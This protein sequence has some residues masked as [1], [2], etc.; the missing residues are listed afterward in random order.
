MRS[1][2]GGTIGRF[3]ATL[4]VHVDLEK[5]PQRTGNRTG[6]GRVIDVDSVVDV[7]RLRCRTTLEGE[8]REE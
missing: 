1:D 7:T 2:D 4:K 3:A 6:V 5:D 8:E